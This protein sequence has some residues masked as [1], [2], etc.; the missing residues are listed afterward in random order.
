MNSLIISLA[1][2]LLATTAQTTQTTQE[3]VAATAETPAEQL[4]PDAS[5]DPSVDRAVRAAERAA[6]AAEQTAKAVERIAAELE[7]QRGSAAPA[8]AAVVVVA[9]ETAAPP[10]VEWTGAIGASLI[11][12]TG[13]AD[14][15]TVSG[16]AAFERKSESWI[17][18]FKAVGAY[19]QSRGSGE[20]ESQVVAL[21]ALGQ[22]RVDRRFTDVV[23]AYGLV[24]L[25]TDHLRSI[26]YRTSVEAGAAIVWV[27]QKAEN[28]RALFLRTDL[29]MR[30]ADESRQQ[31]YPTREDLDDI[32]LVAP[33]L[34]ASFRYSLSKDVAFVED[35]EV[36]LNILGDFRMLFTST[37]KLSARLIENVSLG[38]G[39]QITH[40]S[41]PA[42]G[43]VPTDTALTVGIEVAL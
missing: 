29:A 10:A 6:E 41:A 27:D 31:Y 3:Q 15:L 34:G 42:E 26:E 9:E 5:T 37:S 7:R 43:K 8:A 30:Y 17:L 36:L 35:A 4:D 1:I 19:G 39:F 18:G 28:D 21:N 24:I 16:L 38:V 22:V 2:G 13:N 33:K 32:R 23:S 20:V 14:T 11:S 40:D 12:L 25:E